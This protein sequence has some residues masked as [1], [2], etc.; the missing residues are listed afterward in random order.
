MCCVNTRAYRSRL[1]SSPVQCLLTKVYRIPSVSGY[2]CS[3]TIATWLQVVDVFFSVSHSVC[4]KVTHVIG[5]A[6]MLLMAAM[7]DHFCMKPLKSCMKFEQ[8]TVHG[9][10]IAFT[11]TARENYMQSATGSICIPPIYPLSCLGWNHALN[12]SQ[13]MSVQRIAG[14]TW[15]LHGDSEKHFLLNQPFLLG[16]FLKWWYPTTMGFSY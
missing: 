3:M 9:T 2:Q 1:N 10:K 14:L 6:V 7:P 4:C 8:C 5:N 16:G 12:Y 11:C 13:A 15:G